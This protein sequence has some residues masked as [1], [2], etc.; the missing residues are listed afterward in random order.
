MSHDADT[1]YRMK[2]KSRN[3]KLVSKS[4]LMAKAR[5]LS[6]HGK[7]TSRYEG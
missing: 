1:L 2:A 6:V 5:V 3:W 4:S 7:E